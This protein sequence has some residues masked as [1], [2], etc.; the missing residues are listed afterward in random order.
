MSFHGKYKNYCPSVCL[1]D[2]VEDCV[3]SK[4]KKMLKIGWGVMGS[5]GKSEK[6]KEK[7]P[8]GW[9]VVWHRWIG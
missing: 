7:K 5:G 2:K 9:L 1:T 8:T 4:R 6:E 3:P